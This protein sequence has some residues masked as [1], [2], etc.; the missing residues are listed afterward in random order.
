MNSAYTRAAN[1]PVPDAHPN[2]LRALAML[3]GIASAKASEC[4]LLELGC[5][6]GVQLLALGL[7][8]P[9][10]NFVGVDLDERA[11]SIGRERAA[12]LGIGNVRLEA[13]DLR[14]LAASGERFDY[15]VG[16]GLYSWVADDVRTSLLELC[17]NVLKP[18]GLGFLSFNALPGGYHRQMARELVRL[19]ADGVSDATERVAQARALANDFSR[20]LSEKNPPENALR[21]ELLH[22]LRA[23]DS[24][25]AL[26]YLGEESLA[27]TLV[28]FAE[29]L[30]RH[31]LRY[32]ADAATFDLNPAPPRWLSE[33]LG[34]GADT[35]QQQQFLDYL[36]LRRFRQA[37]FCRADTAPAAMSFDRAGEL[38]VFSSAAPV[39]KVASDTRKFRTLT[40]VE[41]ETTNDALKLAFIELGNRWPCG[42]RLDELAA[43]ITSR[44]SGSSAVPVDDLARMLFTN[45]LGQTVFV[46]AELPHCA[47]EPGERPVATPLAR[48]QARTG[49]P[50]TNQHHIHV[51]VQPA[52][53]RSL[54]ALLDGT[55]DRNELSTRMAEGIANGTLTVPGIDP[56]AR[57]SWNDQIRREVDA[58]LAKLARFG[59]I[60]S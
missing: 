51:D 45:G 47:R 4:R 20:G 44:L 33:R 2:R 54:L 50:V 58:S 13:R 55:L 18:H 22:M 8:F 46:S 30:S 9:K 14:E 59:L 60:L 57:A 7:E 25:I 40:G 24:L 38:S 43:L 5:G 27:F 35:I 1:K 26:E 21:H 32:L 41:F 3:C 42:V 12:E 23:S 52:F 6:E 48:L 34:S 15:V 16:H 31:R 56:A 49:E 28:E 11:V 39:S 29:R 37:V 19:A 17:A 53:N 10:A 36:T